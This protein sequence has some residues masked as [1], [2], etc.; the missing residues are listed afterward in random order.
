MTL[1]QPKAAFIAG[2]LATAQLKA[3]AR[4]PRDWT[5]VTAL[6][7]SDTDCFP[8][9]CVLPTIFPP[10]SFVHGATGATAPRSLMGRTAS[11]RGSVSSAT[12]MPGSP[13]SGR[14]LIAISRWSF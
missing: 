6:T 13:P 4:F 5:G 8:L 14:A 2:E 3:A 1:G 11:R 12:A 10:V 9:S 7:V